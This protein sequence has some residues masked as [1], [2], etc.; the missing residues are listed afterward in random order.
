MIHIIA[1]K[2]LIYPL[3]RRM[4]SGLSGQEIRDPIK[5]PRSP[6]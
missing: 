3:C 5:L 6:E 1:T 4:S 2:S